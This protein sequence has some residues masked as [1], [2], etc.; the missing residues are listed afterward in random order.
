MVTS[1]SSSHRSGRSF[2]FA[3][4]LAG[5][6][7]WSATAWA[8]EPVRLYLANDDH[9]DY[10]WTADAETYGRVFVE[11]I[12]YNL[13]LTAQTQHLPPAWQNRFN[14]DGSLWLWEYERRKSPAEFARV[15]EL[16]RS[17]H[18]SVPLNTIISCYGAQPTE[19][20]LR[21]MYYAGQLERRFGLRFTQALATENQT[22]PLG[23]ASLWA[24]SGAKY[25]WRGICGCATRLDKTDLAR[26]DHEIYWYTGL[27]G[28]RVLMKWHSFTPPGS[29]RNGGYAEAFDPVAALRFL[30]RD[31]N[32]LH[33][34]RQPEASE[35]YALRAAF[36]FGWDALDRKTGQVYAADPKTYPLVDHFHR[37]AQAATSPA[38]EV[39]VSNQEDFFAAFADRYGAQLPT[40]SVTYGNEWDLY[41]ASLAETSSRVRRA[42]ERL[43][44]AEALA[45]LV[46]LPAT[47]E[48]LGTPTPRLQA[49]LNLGLYWE[50]DFTADGPIPRPQ[51]AAW[52]VGLA[53]QIEHYVDTLDRA[54]TDRLSQ[55][56][57]ATD[58][59]SFW[60][61]NPLSW[62][63]TDAADFPYAGPEDIHVRDLL[64]ASD[65]PHQFLSREGGRYLRIL[66]GDVP[67]LGYKVYAIQPGPG[68]AATT[69][70]ATWVGRK[71]ANSQLQVTVEKDGAL[72]S[73]IDRRDPGVELAATIGGWMSN[74]FAA[75]EADGRA[76]RLEN[77]GPVSVTL[78][79]T[80]EAGRD[81]TTRLTLYRDAN[82]LDLDNTIS[83]NF[84]DLRHWAFSFN[85]PAPQVH[86]EEIGA[87]IQLRTAAAGGHYA[88]RNARYDYATLNHF[89]DLADG[90]NTRGITLSNWD[91]AFVRLGESSPRALDTTTAQF[92]VLAGGQVDGDR[93][94][95]RNQNGATAF[96]H[97]FALRAH[98]GYHAASALRFALEHQN[99]L[100]TGAAS[101]TG[102]QPLPRP[103]FSLLEVDDPA[104]LVWALKPAEDGAH[105]G[106]VV[107][108]WNVADRP[109]RVRLKYAGRLVAAYR[110]THLETDLA[111][112]PLEAD[113]AS[114]TL[115]LASQ[116]LLT[117]RLQPR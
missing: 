96:R 6:L 26:R 111:P 62:S 71:F 54:A 116:Q 44:S 100:R 74:D 106:L 61:F 98:R 32:F 56:L 20:V 55:R 11:Q 94:G 23:L 102:P 83:E 67:A 84:G 91:C 12:D 109:T 104:V 50:H 9:T 4:L 24:G 63:R 35:P 7:L 58:Q 80:S 88:N 66:A 16:V 22:L 21:G 90:A 87:L 51:R 79:A 27:D 38:A 47:T 77:A 43:R 76:L 75:H 42:V 19:A 85:L 73:L 65:V 45:A 1:F 82:R 49:W 10:L 86:T 57:P 68:Q 95:I 2:P 60:V 30:Q 108:L 89:L 93:L 28:Q 52:H 107:R 110:T 113:A 15:I 114:V 105:A 72:S 37:L 70:A 59:P 39:V 53:D 36:G 81:H 14:T 5:A 17:G 18:L 92:H 46:G 25:S 112:L 8:A 64:R 48:P 99:P 34:Y 78:C 40:E 3:P 13:Q 97:R 69:P 31:A 29:K 103:A 101:G 115:E 33:R 41:S 117:C